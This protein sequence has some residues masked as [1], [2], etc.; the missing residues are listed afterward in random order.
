[1]VDD[2]KPETQIDRQTRSGYRASQPK[3]RFAGSAA[4]TTN[5]G[6]PTPPESW[7][8]KYGGLLLTSLGIVIAVGIAVT[9]MVK[10][11]NFEKSQAARTLKF[12]AYPKLQADLLALQGAV[13]ACYA[14][15]EM[16]VPPETQSKLGITTQQDWFEQH[17]V[18]PVM[19][20][21]N[22]LTQDSSVL[23]NQVSSAIR[24]IVQETQKEQILSRNFCVHYTGVLMQHVDEG[25]FGTPAQDQVVAKAGVM[26]IATFLEGQ[27]QK[28]NSQ[29]N[30]ELSGD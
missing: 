12:A 22:Q 6:S 5:V 11:H 10:N 4:S 13:K 26:K 19:T 14:S 1:M 30:K 27:G 9:T 24:G 7:F 16:V 15:D 23:M 29:I 2:G 3:R 20:A 28:L 8:R 25:D 17:I 18:E 21:S